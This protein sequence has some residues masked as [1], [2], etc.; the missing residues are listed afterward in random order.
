ME[1]KI[2]EKYV[3]ADPADN[4][5]EAEYKDS[6]TFCT[7]SWEYAKDEE[8]QGFKVGSKVKWNGDTQEHTIEFTDFREDVLNRQDTHTLSYVDHE[9]N[10]CLLMGSPYWFSIEWFDKVEEV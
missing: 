4:L 8:E 5:R 3:T 10:T 6:E 1:F 9:D 2:D 7:D